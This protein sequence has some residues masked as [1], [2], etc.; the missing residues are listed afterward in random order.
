ML[1]ASHN[2]WLV[3]ASLGIAMLAGFTGLSLLKGASQTT[4]DKRKFNVALA[5]ISMGGGIWSMHFVAM[6]G[7]Q[8]PIPFLY[9]ILTTLASALIAI[10]VV[11]MALLILH[12]IKRDRKTMIAAGVLVG[13]GIVVMH[14][15][16]MSGM[17]G[18]IAQYSLHGVAFTVLL[19]VTLGVITFL[20]AYSERNQ[21]NI[22]MGTVFFGFAVFAVHFVAMHG[23]VFHAAPSEVTDHILL[24][25]EVLAIGVSVTAFILCGA[26]LLTGITFISPA[27]IA[28]ETVSENANVSSNSSGQSVLE[29]ASAINEAELP[30]PKKIRIPYERDGRSSFMTSDSVM[31]IRAEGHYTLI[32]TAKEKLFCPLS[33]SEIAKRLNGTPFINCHRSYLINPEHVSEFERKKD[34]GLCY[35]KESSAIEKVPVSRTK[36]K[37]VQTALG[38]T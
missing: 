10:L 28:H 24:S 13:I 1:E 21:F 8:L 19:A 26:F 33:I 25:N 30:E 35:F 20:V 3:A 2:Y 38:L 11:G 27:T 37:I 32:Y 16:G 29:R 17:Q 23:T 31:A 36:L 15:L 6:L 14:Y 22:L 34:N 4:V 12:F 9:E 18:A 5:S 7:L